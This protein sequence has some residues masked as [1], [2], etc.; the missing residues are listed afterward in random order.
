MTETD[1]YEIIRQKLKLGPLYAP[2]H[3]K[4][5]ELLRIFWTEDEAKLLSQFN[6]CDTLTSLN[7][8]AERTGMSK[9]D[10]KEKLKS[11]NKK[12][13]I[14]R[15]GSKYTLLPLVP[16][17]FEQYFIRR[18]DTKENLKKVAEIYRFLFKEF[19]P[20]MYIES[21]L[22]LFRP[23][24]PLDAKEKLI[25]VNAEFDVKHQVLPF[26]LIEELINKYD[27]F[28]TVPCQCRLIGEYT[29]EPCKHAPA[30]LGCFLAGNVADGAIQSGAPAMNKEQAIEFLKKTEKAGLVHN[31]IA[32]SSPESSLVIC[33]CCNC[34]CGALMA[35]REHKKVSIWPSNYIPIFN[36]ELCKKCELCMKK[37]PMGAIY[38]HWPNETNKTDDHMYL[39]QEYCIGCGVCAATCPNS[40]IKLKKVRTEE[41]KEKQKIGN[42]SFLE[43]LM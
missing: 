31:C 13:T 8:L 42:K 7:E 22:K 28:T 14:T 36:N 18:Q 17:I 12:K 40:A 5:D 6:S 41:Y 1:Y 24:L 3:K 35:A 11:P 19:L 10:I 39:N 4:V 29:G 23:R 37:C 38:H 20:S 15:I 9:E 26:E 33:N 25:E 34:H 30:T 2:K 16:G 21:N 32:D 43:L 27:K